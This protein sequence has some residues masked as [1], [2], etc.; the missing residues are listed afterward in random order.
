MTKPK[1]ILQATKEMFNILAGIL[2]FKCLAVYYNIAFA[3]E[4]VQIECLKLNNDK[5]CNKT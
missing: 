5:I 2:G 4:T 1:T 3:S